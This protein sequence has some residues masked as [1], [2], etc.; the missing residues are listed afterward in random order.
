MNF[1]KNDSG[2]AIAFVSCVISLSAFKDF[3]EEKIVPIFSYRPTM[4]DMLFYATIGLV[5]AF[6]FFLME[7]L[8]IS[9]QFELPKL[10]KVFNVL[11][12][13][14]L[15]IS[16]ASPILFFSSW[17]LSSISGTPVMM[18]V[19]II[20]GLLAVGFVLERLID[21]NNS[22]EKI[23]LDFASSYYNEAFLHYEKSEYQRCIDKSIKSVE[24]SLTARIVGAGYPV[25][26]QIYINYYMSAY[27]GRGVITRSDIGAL[28]NFLEAAFLHK[29]RN[30]DA[31]PN[32]EIAKECLDVAESY[33]K[34]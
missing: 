21:K 15:Y 22:A 17:L 28:F 3:L 33:L 26:R 19:A 16:A 12:H 7:Q 18:V 29:M 4:Y 9:L 25:P 31:E 1:L 13:L 2:F 23:Y 11:S 20:I 6:Y 24:A 30:I 5:L 34:R 10:I 14:F 32:K 27:G 8:V